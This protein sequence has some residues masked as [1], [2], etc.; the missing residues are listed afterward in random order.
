MKGFYSENQVSS[1]LQIT[2][3]FSWWFIL[4]GLNF[5][6]YTEKKTQIGNNEDE[7]VLLSLWF[8]LYGLIFGIYTEK[9]YNRQQWGWQVF[10]PAVYRPLQLKLFSEEIHYEKSSWT[11]F[12]NYLGL[13]EEGYC[14]YL[15]AVFPLP[16]S[17]EQTFRNSLALNEVV[18]LWVICFR[19]HSLLCF[20]FHIFKGDTSCG[21]LVQ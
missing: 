10:T 12:N 7:R 9:N 20:L 19:V 4:Y 13:K 1:F 21:T 2:L 5:G 11:Y 6:I 14:A 3:H 15:P 17:E 18:C 16:F 8:I